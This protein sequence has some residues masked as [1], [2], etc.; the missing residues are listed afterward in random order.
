MIKWYDLGTHARTQPFIVK[1]WKIKIKERN[2]TI[3]NRYLQTGKFGLWSLHL[4]VIL[5]QSFKLKSCYIM[6]K[7]LG[8]FG[9]SLGWGCLGNFLLKMLMWI[10][11]HFK[12]NIMDEFHLK[13]LLS[14]ATFCLKATVEILRRM[15]IKQ[16][17]FIVIEWYLELGVQTFKHR[18]T[19]H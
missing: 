3:D 8:L 14:P 18:V 17:C 9:Q 16:K 7:M 5:V 12:F 2:N 11:F 1:D 15:R 4:F 13:H 10:R 6:W 19:W